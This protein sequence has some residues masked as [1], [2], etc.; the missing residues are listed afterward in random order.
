MPPFSDPAWAAVYVPAILGVVTFFTPYVLQFVMNWRLS[1]FK[2]ISDES[3]LN[4]P[5]PLLPRVSVSLDGNPIH[6]PQGAGRDVNLL[7]LSVRNCGFADIGKEEYNA[8]IGF[9]FAGREILDLTAITTIPCGLIDLGRPERAITTSGSNATPGKIMLPQI[10]LN[11]NNSVTIS[12]LLKGSKGNITPEG[13]IAHG[14]VKQYVDRRITSKFLWKTIGCL[15]LV[16]SLAMIP[17]LYYFYS[18]PLIGPDCVSDSLS[19]GGSTAMYPLVNQVALTYQ[20]HCPGA[21][22]TVNKNM[23]ASEDGLLGVQNGTLQI[24][25][26]DIT[27]PIFVVS[28]TTTSGTRQLSSKM[29]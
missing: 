11:R 13:A 26:S 24:G 28:R 20:A 8:S 25:D 15:L 7:V 2:V 18:R 16:V 6:T 14:K 17:L 27:A 21:S 22:I 3:F 4:I 9:Q 5:A 1:T 29:F 19:I 12:A 23:A 10:G